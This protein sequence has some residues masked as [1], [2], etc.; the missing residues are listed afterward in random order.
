MKLGTKVRVKHPTGGVRRDDVFVVVERPAD[1]TMEGLTWVRYAG[2]A[3]RTESY[4]ERVMG[5]HASGLERV[6]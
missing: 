5:F 1:R 6:G 2:D 4:R 3:L